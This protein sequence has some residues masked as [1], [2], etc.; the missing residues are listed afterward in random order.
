M[1]AKDEDHREV[2]A[3]LRN[4]DVR[5]VG[6]TEKAVAGC[7][8]MVSTIF[9]CSDEQYLLTLSEDVPVELFQTCVFVD[10]ITTGFEKYY[11]TREEALQGHAD[12]CRDVEYLGVDIEQGRMQWSDVSERLRQQQ[13]LREIAQISQE[14][15]KYD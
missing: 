9:L 6:L 3:L 2:D 1:P 7:Y 13:G 8:V 11:K 5:R 4:F 14:S 12:V 15:G 10:K